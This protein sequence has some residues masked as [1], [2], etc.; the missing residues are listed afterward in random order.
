MGLGE[1]IAVSA[2]HGEG[3]AELYTALSA[4]DKKD[5]HEEQDMGKDG[6]HE[7]EENSSLGKTWADPETPRILRLAFVGRPYVVQ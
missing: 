6:D 7:I 3:M 2:E 4:L 1:P 5:R